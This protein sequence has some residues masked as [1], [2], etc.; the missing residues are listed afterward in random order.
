MTDAQNFLRA[1]QNSDT[2]PRLPWLEW[3]PGQRVVVRYREEGGGL[4]DALGTLV[5]TAPDHVVI[6]A[7]RGRVRVE[8]R[9]MV[10][11]KRVLTPSPRLHTE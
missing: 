7:R 10:T 6:E 9:H 8:A 5:E 11:G 2:P 3:E 4:R 1:R